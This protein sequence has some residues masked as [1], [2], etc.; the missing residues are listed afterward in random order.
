MDTITSARY[1]LE[2]AARRRASFITKSIS[3]VVAAA[4]F[5][6]GLYYVQFDSAAYKFLTPWDFWTRAAAVAGLA[7]VVVISFAAGLRYLNAGQAPHSPFE[8]EAYYRFNSSFARAVDLGDKERQ[9]LA[10]EIREQ[11]KH[12]SAQEFLKELNDRVEK[13]VAPKLREEYLEVMTSATRTRLMA[14]ITALTRRGSLNLLLGISI[15]MVGLSFLGAAVY[16]APS[17]QSPEQFLMHF[18]PRLSLVA[19]MELFA[20]FFLR[21]YKVSLQET[22]YFQNELTNAEA[23][24]L[25]VTA[26][27]KGQDG[28]PIAD[29]IS[30]LMQ[31]DRNHVLEKGQTTAQLEQARLEKESLGDILKGLGLHLA[32]K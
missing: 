16:N 3:A 26:A 21:L 32:K 17:G 13:L 11:L 7:T 14:E 28:K 4:A 23:R 31:V 27:L 29:V 6:L 15:T 8:R 5:T 1:R 24:A 25:A 2:Q 30:G 19:I 22:K 20:Y 18:L 9:A 12:E 10:A